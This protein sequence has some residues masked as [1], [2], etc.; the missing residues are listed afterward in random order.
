MAVVVHDQDFGI[1][2][3]QQLHGVGTDKARAARH[4]D[5]G[6]VFGRRR[7]LGGLA[8]S[9]RR[10]PSPLPT[11]AQTEDELHRDAEQ[12]VMESPA[13]SALISKIQSV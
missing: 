2:R 13:R 9:S 12:T 4:G 8:C 10:R 7:H 6:A 11:A 3:Q 1:R 5:A